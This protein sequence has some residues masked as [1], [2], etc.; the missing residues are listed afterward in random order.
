MEYPNIQELVTHIGGLVREE[1]S[2]LCS[3][4]YLFAV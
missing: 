3:P 4:A 2:L 1:G